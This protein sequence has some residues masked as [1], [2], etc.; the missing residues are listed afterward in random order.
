MVAKLLQN[1]GLRL[2]SDSK[3]LIKRVECK[4][5]CSAGK[6]QCRRKEDQSFSLEFFMKFVEID[7]PS[8]VLWWASTAKTAPPDVPTTSGSVVTVTSRAHSKNSFHNS[9]CSLVAT[10][11]KIDPLPLRRWWENSYKRT[12][13]LSCCFLSVFGSITYTYIGSP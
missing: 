3:L 4:Y 1:K 13:L 9:A 12:S 8:P 10:K 5:V 11:T 7:L 6:I 2:S